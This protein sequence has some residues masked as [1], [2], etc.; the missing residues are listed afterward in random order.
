MSCSIFRGK[1]VEARRAGMMAMVFKLEVMSIKD[2]WSS[3]QS[4]VFRN[5]RVRVS[6]CVQAATGLETDGIPG[7]D[8]VTITLEAQF[9]K[10]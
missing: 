7:G 6:A 4:A 8:D 1:R 2:S 9:V 3:P 10:A 5:P